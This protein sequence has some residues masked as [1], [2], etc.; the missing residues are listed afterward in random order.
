M[1]KH[2]ETS[3]TNNGYKVVIAVPIPT[4]SFSKI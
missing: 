3:Q 4:S 2:A 1:C